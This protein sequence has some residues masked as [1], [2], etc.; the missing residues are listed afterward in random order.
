MARRRSARKTSINNSSSPSSTRPTASEGL[1]TGVRAAVY[2]RYSSQNQRKESIADQIASCRRLA[3]DRGFVVLEQHIYVDEAQSGASLQRPGLIA[4]VD[5]A[6]DK[7]FDL[8]LVDDLSR[9]ARDNM[10]MYMLV[11]LANLRFEG[12]RVVSVADRVDTAGEHSRLLIQVRGMLNEHHLRDLGQKTHRGQCGQKDRGYG[13]GESTY[14][15]LT[16]PVGEMRLDKHGRERPAGFKHYV[17]PLDAAVISGIFEDFAN[18]LSKLGIVQRLN[19]EGVPAPKRCRSGWNVS[20][21]YR[22]LNNSKYVGIW[23]WNRTGRVRDPYTGA[24]RP[25]AKPES[26]HVIQKD[27]RFRIVS[28]DLWDAVQTRQAAV[29]KE[30][31]GERRGFSRDQGS[32]TLVYP[33]HLFDGLFRCSSCGARMTLAGGKAGG[34]YGCSGRRRRLCDNK[35]TVRR[36]LVE[37]ILL[38][39][40]CD[41]LLEPGAVHRVLESLVAEIRKLSRAASGKLDTRR[42]EYRA[43]R[44]RLDRLVEFVAGGHAPDSAVVAEAIAEAEARVSQL[45]AEIDA[46]DDG[47][48]SDLR[49]PSV[50]W[51]AERVLALK[52]LLERRTVESARLLRRL[53]GEDVVLEPVTPDSGR[54]YYVARTAIDAFVLV[55]PSGPSGGPDGGSQSL[56]W[57]RRRESN[58][59]P[60]VCLRGTLHACPPLNVSLPVSKDGEK[61]PEAS[62]EKSRRRVSAPRATASP[63]YDVQPRPAGEDEVNASLN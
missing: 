37:S 13:V 42:V 24:R 34:Y 47:R 46:L 4:L 45:S 49:S 50:E 48:R 8:V 23:V 63:L 62:A 22:I 54:P 56:R 3:Q 27:E 43:A 32:R 35:L 28:Q 25:V 21:V 33:K 14:G 57:W 16:K 51:V 60:K 61:P 59:R 2:A 55:E 41:R 10:Y 17:N 6:K 1:V 11:T 30:F 19:E 15:Y 40:I 18:G 26:E 53:L 39:A 44:K 38:G 5:A 9:L 36:S 52:G 7:L 20:T 29:R 31:P 58:P 12:V